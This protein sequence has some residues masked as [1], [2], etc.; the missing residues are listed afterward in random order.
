MSDN[1]PDWPALMRP[2]TLRAYL[3]CRSASDF[4]RMMKRLK[5]RGYPGVDPF[6]KRHVRAVVDKYISPNDAVRDYGEAEALRAI[7]E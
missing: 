7:N 6:C 5:D 3:D 2:E 4:A 1:R